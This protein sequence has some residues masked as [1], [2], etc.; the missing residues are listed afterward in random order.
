MGISVIFI[1][2]KTFISYMFWNVMLPSLE[3]S[4]GFY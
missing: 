1:F 3:S 2:F 4:E